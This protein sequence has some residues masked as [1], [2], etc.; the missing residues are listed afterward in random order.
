MTRINLF[1]FSG[2]MKTNTRASNAEQFNAGA[3]VV[4]HFDINKDYRRLKPVPSLE[5]ITNSTS[6]G[7][8][9]VGLGI[10]SG[11]QVLYGVGE[12]LTNWLASSW[13]YR[14]RV[15]ATTNT[16]YFPS[17]TIPVFHI[18]LSVMPSGFF[19]HSNVDSSDIRVTDLNNNILPSWVEAKYTTPSNYGSLWV[20]ANIQ[21]VYIYYGNSSATSIGYTTEYGKVNTFSDFFRY[22]SW[23]ETTGTNSNWTSRTGSILNSSDLSVDLSDSD[24][25]VFDDFYTLSPPTNSVFLVGG[26]SSDNMRDQP[27]NNPWS[28]LSGSFTYMALI[29]PNTTPTASDIIYSASTVADMSITAGRNITFKVNI[30]PGTFITVTGT[31]PLTASAWNSVVCTFQNGVGGK[32]YIN[33]V[34]TNSTATAD[35]LDN[36]GAGQSMSIGIGSGARLGAVGIYNSLMSANDIK[37]WHSTMFETTNTWT[38]GSEETFTS[39]TP[40]YSGGVQVYEYDF[41]TSTWG[42]TVVGGLPF[43]AFTQSD[44]GTNVP[45]YPLRS[46]FLINPTG[47]LPAVFTTNDSGYA[48]GTI[49]LVMG[50]SVGSYTGRVDTYTFK[51]YDSVIADSRFTLSSATRFPMNQQEAVDK[52]NYFSMGG[53][54]IASITSGNIVRNVFTPYGSITDLSNYGQYMAISSIYR[55]K[56][57]IQLWDLSSTTADE[58]I[59]MGKGHIRAIG[60][61]D[62]YLFGVID[63]YTFDERL[64][65]GRQS[66]EVRIYTGNSQTQQV[67][68][69]DVPVTMEGEFTHVF[70]NAVN[71]FSTGLSDAYTWYAKLPRDTAR[72]EFLNGIWT[73]G[74]NEQAPAPNISVYCDTSGIADLTQVVSLGNQLFVLDK[75]YKVWQINAS[76]EYTQTSTFESLVYDDATPQDDKMLKSIE[77]YTDELPNGQTVSVYYRKDDDLNY[78]AGWV[79]ICDHTTG[80]SKESTRIESTELNLPSF[81]EIQFK[82]TSTGGNADVT[83]FSFTFEPTTKY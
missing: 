63:V 33:G 64:S 17:T 24:P 7:Y 61:V 74:N 6:R 50:Q 25:G 68:R 26:T 65:A 43:G 23:S 41:D 46:S 31:T 73:L 21:D 42:E 70:D 56:S 69:Y 19:T 83:G 75:D 60:T 45:I 76:G 32:I 4:S 9:I 34:L 52:L 72:T 16:T 28:G 14:V 8:K 38:A 58:F 5:E 47:N 12:K 54:E 48:Y 40:T 10:S 11:E 35:N 27:S 36:E 59:D 20:N 80:K 71:C 81:K 49:T 37:S 62:Q 22:F 29:R 66:M 18:P 44:V 55:N 51:K 39:I 57:A 3:S 53:A 79:K 13:L 82:I 2:G 30:T 67:Y 15:N 78:V 1:N 77:L